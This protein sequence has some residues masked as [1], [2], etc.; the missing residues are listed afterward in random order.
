M[1]QNGST[2]SETA[3]AARFQN[4]DQ[5][6]KWL[7]GIPSNASGSTL[8]TIG[9]EL[10]QFVE[11]EIAPAT[12]LETL[13]VLRH[14]ITQIRQELASGYCGK[15]LPLAPS[16]YDLWRA[17]VDMRLAMATGY[18]KCLTNPPSAAQ[19]SAQ[20]EALG[21][22]RA[23]AQL[24]HAICDYARAYTGVPSEIWKRIHHLYR[25]AEARGITDVLAHDSSS[26]TA[27][28]PS[29]RM[30]YLHTLLFA[31]AQP[32]SLSP[33]QI[34]YVF[35]RLDAWSNLATLHTEALD[36]TSLTALA[37]DLD[38]HD[39]MKLLRHLPAGPSLRHIGTQRLGE[40]LKSLML[41]LRQGGDAAA[42]GINTSIAKPA[43]ERLLTNLYIQWCSAGTG[44]TS[45]RSLSS[46]KAMVTVTIP[47]MHF[48]ISGL[49]FRQP[50]LGATREE[51]EDLQVFGHITQRTMQKLVSQRSSAFE[52]WSI[53][54]ESSGGL[55]MLCRQ[56]DFHTRIAHGQL[57]GLMKRSDK[58][59]ELVTVQRVL[60]RETGE[61]EV[62]VRHIEGIPLSVA[63]R[64]SAPGRPAAGANTDSGAKYE[65]ALLLPAISE[66]SLP[67]RLLLE[68]GWYSPGSRRELYASEKTTVQLKE[69]MDHGPNFEQASFITL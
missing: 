41:T 30:T 21:C 14:K 66:K 43:L 5:C 53:G 48:Y 40:T 8:E 33:A 1:I 68:P 22:Q 34:E 11:S 24:L 28:S 58:P 15:A 37:V 42:L 31:A 65:R 62:G 67:A 61:L 44:R 4:E 45:A 9:V 25:H 69:L 12:R 59:I 52:P 18:E 63:V 64:V 6:R 20:L 35:N 29:C 60:Q 39:G 47:A 56:P 32:Y 16:E 3:Q 23:I 27:A 26:G 38:S 10:R 7:A 19:N 49:A 36:G 46:S 17:I 57:L 2:T 54:N 51:E 50:G 13:E 55:F